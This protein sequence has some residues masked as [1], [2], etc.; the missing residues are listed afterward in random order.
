MAFGATPIRPSP[1]RRNPS[2]LLSS[3]ASSC[4]AFRTGFDLLS[5]TRPPSSPP[6]ALFLFASSG[7][8]RSCLSRSV[9]DLSSPSPR[10]PLADCLLLVLR[11]F[12]PAVFRRPSSLLRPLLTSPALSHGRPP[13]V[14]CMDILARAARLYLMRLSVTLGFSRSLARVVCVKFSKKEIEKRVGKRV[15]GLFTNAW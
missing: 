14:R 6:P 4:A 10:N 15:E 8:D 1:W 2:R 9:S 7:T 5:A 12:A 3:L 13:R 11:P